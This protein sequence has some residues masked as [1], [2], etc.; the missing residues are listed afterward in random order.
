[1]DS[2][3]PNTLSSPSS[4]GASTAPSS[5]VVVTSTNE[6]S[7]TS[8]AAPS[9]SVTSSQATA[10]FSS[11]AQSALPT[12]QA[13]PASA[14]AVVPAVPAAIAPAM[15]KFSFSFGKMT[16]PP[17]PTASN[18]ATASVTAGATSTTVG[19]ASTPA[20]NPMLA[21]TMNQQ[22]ANRSPGQ[23]GP[24]SI[25]LLKQLMQARENAAQQQKQAQ[26]QAQQQ[27]QQ[28]ASAS[29]VSTSPKTVGSVKSEVTG[30]TRSPVAQLRPTAIVT[31]VKPKTELQQPQPRQQSTPTDQNGLSLKRPAPPEFD[32]EPAPP[33]QHSPQPAIQ[34][35]AAI[36]PQTPLAHRPPRGPMADVSSPVK[37]P[38]LSRNAQ[39][40]MRFANQWDGAVDDDAKI[41]TGFA[42]QQ[43][44]MARPPQYQHKLVDID[45][46]VEQG[47]ITASAP[48]MEPNSRTME[49]AETGAPIQQA[50]PA[51]QPQ[52]PKPPQQQQQQQLQQQPAPGFSMQ[53]LMGGPSMTQTSPQLQQPPQRQMPQR[54]LPP[55][56]P[57]ADDF[58][59]LLASYTAGETRQF[60]KRSRKKFRK[61]TH[62]QFGHQPHNG[63][64]PHQSNAETG[65]SNGQHRQKMAGLC[66]YI[67]SG[68]C[69][70]GDSCIFSHEFSMKPCYYYHIRRSCA[71]SGDLCKFNH[72][73]ITPEQRQKLVEEGGNQVFEPV[74]VDG[75][76]KPPQYNNN[77]NNSNSNT[78]HTSNFITYG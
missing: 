33:P 55:G 29:A 22:I 35:A 62:Q 36:A 57:E 49:S 64:A 38:P 18:P 15:P 4:S 7:S 63:A 3:T 30:Q 9:K 65:N 51:H 60:D 11:V 16:R 70:Y 21:S 37:L 50:S 47:E 71:F 44:Q 6:V 12:A 74:D 76:T 40:K 67:K 43:Q 61:D 39:R 17:V 14:A 25:D 58:D 1:M 59:S 53:M 20:R 31:P 73:P 8:S 78:S 68:H 42:K 72:G 41:I 34:S 48:S 10:S 66:K 28:Q 5:G 19:A 77:N 13:R 24:S 52:Q 23:A 45:Q 2:N 75:V 54:P 32:A 69:N 27:A 26:E 56:P 46:E